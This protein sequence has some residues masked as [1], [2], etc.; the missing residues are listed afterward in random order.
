[1]PP[2]TIS[3]TRPVSQVIDWVKLLL[4]RPV[5]PGKWFTIGFCAWVGGLG[6]AGFNFN[7]RMGRE[8]LDWERVRTFIIENLY[9]IVPLAIVLLVFG[10][11]TWVALTWVSSR[12]KFMFLHCVALQRAEVS[13]P[14]H[15]FARQGNSLF[16]FRLVLSLVGCAVLLPIM[17]IGLV[18][19]AR[20][21]RGGHVMPGLYIILAGVVGTLVVLSI[22]MFLALKFTTDFVVPIMF[23]RGSSCLQAWREVLG[24]MSAYAGQFVLY[25][26]FQI[27]LGLGIG[28]LVLAVIIGTCCIA[29]CLLIIPYLGTVLLL[30]VLVFTRSYSIHYLAQYGRQYDVH[31]PVAPPMVQT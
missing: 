5:D 8:R 22:G 7:I 2:V 21:L 15:R 3:V 10:A 6:E 4:F 31:P 23:V 9:W 17:A 28:V 24:L 26:L 30:P 12:G 14:W 25:L 13:E 18:I 29:G 20:L 19:F 11:A 27:V 16:V 1:M